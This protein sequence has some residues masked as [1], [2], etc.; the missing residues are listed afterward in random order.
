[1]AST[2][3]VGWHS[4]HGVITAGRLED[5]FD[6][7]VPFHFVAFNLSG[8]TTVEWKRGTRFTRFHAHPGNS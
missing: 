5:F 1:M 2:Q 8:A 7:S 6:Y 3:A 4:I